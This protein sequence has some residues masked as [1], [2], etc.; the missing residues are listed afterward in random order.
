MKNNLNILLFSFL[1]TIFLLLST[2]ASAQELSLSLTPN[3]SEIAAKPGRTISLKFKLTNHGDPT[4]VNIRILPFE[5]KDNRGNI[6][7]L[8]SLQGPIRFELANED[9]KLAVPLFLKN[10]TSRDLLLN[11]YLP[12]TLANQDYYFTLLAESQPPPAQE[13]VVNIRAKALV[14]SN[15]LLTV[16]KDGRIEIKPNISLFEVVPKNK[17]NFLGTKI[18][19]FNSFEK[20]PLIMVVENQGKYLIKPQGGITV[21]GMFA[22]AKQVEIKPQNILAE[23][24]RVLLAHSSNLQPQTSNSLL[25]PGFFMGNYKASATISFGPGT[26]TL[27]AT[28]SFL[29]LPLKAIFIF[30]PIL[31]LITL[32]FKKLSPQKR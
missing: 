21:R 7:I 10:S 26:P 11:I 22:Q 13:G 20:I 32:I 12:E 14:A 9:I 6:N 5:A 17:I 16:T 18:N 30:L 27:Y 23:S 19:L 31:F 24:Q 4:I 28:T 2:K 3:L 25:L 15:L 29:V 1:T 8:S